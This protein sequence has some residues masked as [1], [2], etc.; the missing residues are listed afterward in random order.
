[1]NRYEAM[2]LLDANAAADWNVAEAE[3]KRILVERGGA[4]ILGLKR[5]DERKLSYEIHRQK[6]GIYSLAYFEAPAEKVAGIEHD[7]KLSEMI[8]RMLVLRHER[9]SAEAIEKAM[10]AAPPP[11]APDRSSDIWS[12]R[13]PARGPAM[14]GPR[15]RDGGEV[16][17]I[18]ELAE[19]GAGA[20][21]GGEDAVGGAAER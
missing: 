13:G 1:M 9:L 12:T 6:R 11:R 18:E 20:E 4:N 21:A 15:E 19:V 2:F 8:L 16:E 14:R 5:W 10:T 17:K 3:L 7:A